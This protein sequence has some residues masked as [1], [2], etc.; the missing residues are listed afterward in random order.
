MRTLLHEAAADAGG[1]YLPSQYTLF[2]G[3]TPLEIETRDEA[4]VLVNRCLADYGIKA[5]FKAE[6]RPEPR[7]TDADLSAQ[8][9]LR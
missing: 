5:S 3:E 9:S 1:G 6:A 4:G 7:S 8:R 2:L